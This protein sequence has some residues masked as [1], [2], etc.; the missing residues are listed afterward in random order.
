M[1]EAAPR[2]ARLTASEMAIRQMVDSATL[3]S[4]CVTRQQ[5]HDRFQQMLCD[6]FKRDGRFKL[7]FNGYRTYQI[8]VGGRE[9]VRVKDVLMRWTMA[10][11]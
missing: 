2:P 9:H 8:V 6:E 4:G 7:W 5:L 10:E 1:R 3:G 11:L